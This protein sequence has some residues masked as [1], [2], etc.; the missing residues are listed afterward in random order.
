MEHRY[1]LFHQL[2]MFPNGCPYFDFLQPNFINTLVSRIDMKI[3]Q[4]EN[5]LDKRYNSTIVLSPF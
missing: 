2:H 3:L 4:Y 1:K 5:T